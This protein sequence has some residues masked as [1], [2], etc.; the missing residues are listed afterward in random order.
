MHLLIHVKSVVDLL[1][2]LLPV[3]IKPFRDERS[4]TYIRCILDAYSFNGLS[5]WLLH[6]KFDL[7]LTRDLSI[8]LQ[9]Q[10]IMTVVLLDSLHKRGW[11][12]TFEIFWLTVAFH[13]ATSELWSSLIIIRNKNVIELES[14]ILCSRIIFI[15]RQQCI[16]SPGLKRWV[17]TSIRLWF[18]ANICCLV[19]GQRTKVLPFVFDGKLELTFGWA[20][21]WMAWLVVT[22]K[23]LL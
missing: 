2:V 11:R 9:L 23:A 19:S 17:C 8:W 18:H 16:C 14:V 15:I 3:V 13:A 1:K 20:H 4:A 22:T 7:D 6:P 21:S 5:K 10:W 12:Q